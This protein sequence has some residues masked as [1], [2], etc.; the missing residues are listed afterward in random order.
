MINKTSIRDR[1]MRYV[2]VDTQSDPD[3]RTNPSTEKQKDLSRLLVQE[4]KEMGISDAAMDEYGYVYGT[5]SG[6]FEKESACDLLLFSCGHGP[7]LQRNP[8][9]A[10]PAC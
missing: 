4:M 3:S 8:C 6:H 1:F 2:Q 5:G 10:A 7:G 9:K